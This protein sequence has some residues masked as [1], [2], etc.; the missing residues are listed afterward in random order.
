[1][2]DDYPEHTKLKAVQDQTQAIGEF[3]E[4]A[5]Y[6]HGIRLASD[7]EPTDLRRCERCDPDSFRTRYEVG[8]CPAC[9]T[10]DGW[11]EVTLSPRLMEHTGRP[12]ALVAEWAGIDEDRLEQEKR[13]MLDRLRAANA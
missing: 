10:D 9:E 7:Q 4:W 3:L 5:S 1:M 13:Q 6:T 8:E 2:S 12:M 11:Y